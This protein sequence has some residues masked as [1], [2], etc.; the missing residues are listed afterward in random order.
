MFMFIA[1]ADAANNA[2]NI[3]FGRGVSEVS[4][5]K[6]ANATCFVYEQN[7]YKCACSSLKSGKK[8]VWMSRDGT[9]FEGKLSLDLRYVYATRCKK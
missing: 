7:E 1:D 9:F 8:D 4:D 3:N 5:F 6:Q 2:E